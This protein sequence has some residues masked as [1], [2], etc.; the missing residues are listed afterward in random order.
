MK[1][2]EIIKR[3]DDTLENYNSLSKKTK[4][5]KGYIIALKHFKTLL[6]LR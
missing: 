2:K 6:E 5:E 3:I 4:Q 1:R